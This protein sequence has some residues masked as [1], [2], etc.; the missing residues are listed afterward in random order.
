MGG[1]VK[2]GAGKVMH[3]LGNT[4]VGQVVKQGY[5]TVRNTVNKG[6]AHVEQW[7]KDRAAKKNA[8]KTPEEIAQEKQDRLDKAGDAI[9]PQLQQLLSGGTNKLYLMARLFFWKVRYGLSALTLQSSGEIIAKVNPEL[10]VGR[11][12]KLSA[13]ELGRILSPVFEKAE[14]EYEAALLQNPAVRA[15][16]NQALTRFNSGQPVPAMRRDLQ[17]LVLRHGTPPVGETIEIE[18]GVKMRIGQSGNPAAYEVK[19]GGVGRYATMLASIQKKATE[20]GLNE[21]EVSAILSSNHTTMDSLVDQLAAKLKPQQAK[22]LRSSLQPTLRRASFLTQSLETMRRPGVQT[23]TAL[24]YTFAEYGDVGLG[25]LLGPDGRMAPMTPLGAASND[26]KHPHRETAEQARHQRVGEIMI[27]LLNEAKKVDMYV[28]GE[29]YH[30][31]DLA[32]AVDSW[33][34]TKVSSNQDARTLAR[35]ETQLRLEIRAFLTA[36]HGRG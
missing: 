27:H 28:D 12:K 7:Q 23:P 2:R 15:E 9:K 19:M 1:A 13:E 4:R 22:K 10:T 30:L 20:L 6:K 33:L 29:N 16:Y 31:N 14:R 18:P 11:G 8:G 25:D 21:A 36:Y 32:T 3:A 5:N 35:L 34:R 17:N 26:P 24:A